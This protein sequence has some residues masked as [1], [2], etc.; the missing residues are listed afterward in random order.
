[1]KHARLLALVVGLFA[2]ACSTST[3]GGASAA[4]PASEAT[5]TLSVG[6]AAPEF[7]LPD[8]SGRER[9]LASLRAT[10][11]AVLVFYRGDW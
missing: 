1:M 4:V 6:D 5:T 9:S 8:A 10:G 2:T 11:P 7:S 3:A